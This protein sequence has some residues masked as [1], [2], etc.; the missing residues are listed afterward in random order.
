MQ[1]LSNPTGIRFYFSLFE[2]HTLTDSQ[3]TWYQMFIILTW[4]PLRKGRG[5]GLIFRLKELPMCVPT[6][7]RTDVRTYLSILHLFRRCLP[8]IWILNAYH[9]HHHLIRMNKARKGTCTTITQSNQEW[10]AAVRTT[11]LIKNCLAFALYNKY[12]AKD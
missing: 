3:I 10:A 5:G 12:F 2:V 6:Y 4:V 11:G 9:I 1:R 7:V 8:P